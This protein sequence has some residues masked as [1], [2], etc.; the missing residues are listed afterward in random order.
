MDWA[1]GLDLN[2]CWGMNFDGATRMNE[3]GEPTSSIGIMFY[4]PKMMYISF[5][6]SLTKPC[7]NNVAEYNALIMSLVLALEAEIHILKV[8]GDSQLII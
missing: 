5:S 6:C 2:D 7:S 1:L 4:S 8:Y 3:F